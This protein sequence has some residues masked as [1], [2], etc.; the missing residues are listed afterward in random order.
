MSELVFFRRGE[1]V[2]RFHL[3]ANRV[4]IGRG[5]QS[6]VV[7]PDPAISRQQVAVIRTSA[8]FAVED[9]SGS[10]TLVCGAARADG[11]LGDGED[12]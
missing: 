9:L 3:Q 10:G 8:G 5:E 6:D 12:I 1:E 7:I 2:L 11:P 4:V